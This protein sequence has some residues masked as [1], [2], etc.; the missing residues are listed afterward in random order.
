MRKDDIAYKLPEFDF[1]S[2]VI[3]YDIC[4]VSRSFLTVNFPLQGEKDKKEWEKFQK[5]YR[6]NNEKNLCLIYNSE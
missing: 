1:T 6:N 3:L 5:L 2:A 4:L